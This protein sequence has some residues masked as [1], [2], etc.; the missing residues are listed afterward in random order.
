MIF[1]NEWLQLLIKEF[2]NVLDCKNLIMINIIIRY[3]II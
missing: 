1:E 2:E 3:K